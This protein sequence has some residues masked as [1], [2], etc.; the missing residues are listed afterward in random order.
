MD[1]ETIRIGKGVMQIYK[2]RLWIEFCTLNFQETF[3]Q[4]IVNYFH[5]NSVAKH[6]RLVEGNGFIIVIAREFILPFHEQVFTSMER[7][8]FKG[9]EKV[10]G[11]LRLMEDAERLAGHNQGVAVLEYDFARVLL[12]ADPYKFQVHHP[13]AHSVRVLHSSIDVLLKTEPI[14]MSICC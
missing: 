8:Q 3:C 13:S 5:V 12:G 9:D 11:V 7:R 14:S 10:R 4:N 1:F 2:L 6:H